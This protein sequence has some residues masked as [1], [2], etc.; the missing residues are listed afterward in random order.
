MFIV[1]MQCQQV[2]A[3]SLQVARSLASD[4]DLHIMMF[5]KYGKGFV[6]TCKVSPDAF[7]QTAIQLTYFKVSIHY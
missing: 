4:V 2:I 6:K 5:T 1:V 7:I 3:S